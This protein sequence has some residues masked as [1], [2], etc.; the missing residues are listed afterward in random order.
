MTIIANELQA[1][2]SLV[3]TNDNSNGGRMS[4]NQI[5][6]GVPANVFPHVFSTERQAGSI[7]RRKVFFKVAN[8]ND[9]ILSN[10][11]ICLDGPTQGEDWVHFHVGSQRDTEGDIIGSERKYGAALTTAE[12]VAGASTLVVAVENASLTGIYVDGDTIRVTNKATPDS[13]TGAEEEHTIS[14][15][16]SAAGLEVTII[17]AG[18]LANTYTAGA[19]V[20]SK[21]IPGDLHCTTDNWVETTA[22]G[23]YNESSYPPVCDNIGTVEQTWTLTFTDA[24]NFSVVGDSL[25][26]IGSGNISTDFEPQ[27]PDWSKPYFKLEFVGFGGTW[28]PGDTIVLQ[29][30][31][32]AVPIWETREVPPGAASMASNSVTAIFSGE[33][34]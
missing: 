13:G 11:G 3:V 15:A 8:D 34:A 1:F 31:P 14:G 29:T 28:A 26:N 20:S 4:A 27:N 5:Q 16:P 30:H 33:S 10:T 9:E 25:G 22:S 24:T 23:T 32:A 2:K 19:K 18:Q 12:A 6:S 17:I 21:Y 7:L